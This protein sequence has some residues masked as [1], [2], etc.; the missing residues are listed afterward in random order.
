MISEVAV[1]TNMQLS[2]RLN[3]EGCFFVRASLLCGGIKKEQKVLDTHFFFP[4]IA[5]ILSFIYVYS[6]FT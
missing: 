4:V 1:F 2:R 3:S 5:D 6:M